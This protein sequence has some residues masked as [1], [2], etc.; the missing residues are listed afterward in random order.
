[1]THRLPVFQN[2]P[3][4]AR[5]F[6]S[7]SLAHYTNCNL[8]S[9][10]GL[11]I[12]RRAHA[13]LQYYA[14]SRF[15][16]NKLCFSAKLYAKPHLEPLERQAPDHHFKLG[17]TTGSRSSHILILSFTSSAFRVVLSQKLVF[18]T[19]WFTNSFWVRSGMQDE[20]GNLKY[21]VVSWKRPLLRFR[22]RREDHPEIDLKE[23]G[24]NSDH[25]RAL[26]NVRWLF[27]SKRLRHLTG[28]FFP[29]IVI[30]NMWSYYIA[31]VR[32]KSCMDCPYGS[33]V[34][35]SVNPNHK[36]S[37]WQCLFLRGFSDYLLCHQTRAF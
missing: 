19:K 16:Q 10:E 14:A 37:T 17:W 1:M 9:R 8:C 23:K 13:T 25:W 11:L 20:K 27:G 3:R 15:Q 6:L 7:L 35:R 2:R 22:R 30:Y 32:R 36:A 4:S 28:V 5:F 31:P 26:V 18:V 34:L 12:L 33:S 29:R 21:G 24:R